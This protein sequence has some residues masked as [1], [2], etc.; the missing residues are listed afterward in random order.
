MTALALLLSALAQAEPRPAGPRNPLLD[1]VALQA[2]D[3]LVYLSE[4]ERF[5]ERARTSDPPRSPLERERQRVELLRD[6]AILRLEEERGADLGLDEA[7]IERIRRST[8]EDQQER[9]GLEGYLA[10]LEQ[11]GTD[12]LREESESAQDIY[13][14]LWEMKARGREVGPERAT[15][16]PGVRPGE[17]RHFFEEHRR[18]LETVQL[19]WL[20]VTSES[21][22]SPEGAREK[23]EDARRRV[24]EGEDFGLL[25]EERGVEFRD[26]LGLTPFGPPRSFSE[27][28]I[29]LFAEKAE[30]GALS[31][32]LPL[33]DRRT[34]EP[35]PRLGYQVAELHERR[36]PDFSD[37]AIQRLLG[38]ALVRNRSGLAIGRQRDRL[39]RESFVWVNPLLA[40]PQA[41]PPA[42][43]P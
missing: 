20:I 14:Q 37:P 24:L 16:D 36:V 10:A 12:A 31:E 28:A 18:E 42:P 19:R 29:A 32:V 39:W 23:C 13:R 21:A 6:L 27:Q 1:G 22:G 26:T 5:L 30:V 35:E 43:L 11:K 2:G 38:D 3:S 17:L 9:Q 33:T 7:W 15:L 25:I 8:L 40:P 34:G 4:F 41:A